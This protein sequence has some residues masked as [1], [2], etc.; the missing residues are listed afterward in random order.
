MHTS[1]DMYKRERVIGDAYKHRYVQE[2]GIGDA[3]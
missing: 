2:R 1:I 3:Y